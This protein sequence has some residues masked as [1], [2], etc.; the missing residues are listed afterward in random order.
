MIKTELLSIFA[1]L[2]PW[3]LTDLNHFEYYW[4]I[5]IKLARECKVTVFLTMSDETRQKSALLMVTNTQLNFLWHPVH[6]LWTFVI[7][8]NNFKSKWWSWTKNSL[9][10]SA[11]IRCNYIVVEIAFTF[12]CPIKNFWLFTFTYI[13]T[14]KHL[15]ERTQSSPS[16][17]QTKCRIQQQRFVVISV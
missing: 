9:S 13:T 2:W 16:G 3:S 12:K 10:L 14:Q 6:L 7:S 4:I 1:L 11:K 5:L 15:P 17:H 8:L